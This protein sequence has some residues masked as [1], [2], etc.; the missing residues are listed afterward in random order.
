MMGWL[1][2]A[3]GCT[4]PSGWPAA[5]D[6][7]DAGNDGKPASPVI[8]RQPKPIEPMRVPARTPK[9]LEGLRKTAPEGQAKD[10]HRLLNAAESGEKGDQELLVLAKA[11]GWLAQAKCPPAVQAVLDVAATRDVEKRPALIMALAEEAKTFAPQEGEYEEPTDE[12]IAAFEALV[13]ATE[14]H[15][16]PAD[17][18]GMLPDLMVAL[19]MACGME[20][21]YMD[22]PTPE[23]AVDGTDRTRRTMAPLLQRLRALEARAKAPMADSGEADAPPPYVA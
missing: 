5:D 13:Q 4:W 15:V 3:A 21:W 16:L 22:D 1:A 9:D 2:D 23:Q 8:D 17:W 11:V 19:S 18:P 6:E 7:E 12:Q 20:A 14:D 10:F